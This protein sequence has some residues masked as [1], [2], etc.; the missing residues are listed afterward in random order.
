[1]LL[2]ASK[3]QTMKIALTEI[4]SY[5]CGAAEDTTITENAKLLEINFDPALIFKLHSE[6]LKKI[7][8]QDY[9]Q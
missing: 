7:A 4:C 5:Y 3:T 2:N 1:M 6:C 9:I 8:I